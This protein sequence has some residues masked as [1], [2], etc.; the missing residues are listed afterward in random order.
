MVNVPS[1]VPSAL[2]RAILLNALAP[3]LVKSP[4]ITIFPVDCINISRMIPF[5]VGG[6][7]LASSVPL[8][9]NLAIFDRGV[10]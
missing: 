5:I 3:T 6:V 10:P 7:K 8:I 4:A 2:S 9:F 1:S